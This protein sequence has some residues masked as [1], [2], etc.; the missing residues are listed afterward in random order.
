[1]LHKSRLQFLRFLVGAAL[2]VVAG[3]LAWI[4]VVKADEIAVKADEQRLVKQDLTPV[5]GA[6]LDR[7]LMHMAVSVPTYTLVASPADMKPTEQQ[8]AALQLGELLGLDPAELLKQFKENDTSKYLPLKDKLNLEQKN[9]IEA[10]KLPQMYL[11]QDAQRTYPNKSVA[12]KII[13]YLA[14]GKGAAGLEAQ[15][16][17]QLTGQKGY[18]L[19]EWTYGNTPIESTI[20]EKKE[21][22]PGR[23]LVLSIDLSLQR[24]A[25]AKLDEV[26]KKTDAKRAAIL[27]MDIHTGEILIMA[28]R[29]GADPGDRTTWG[30]PID[31][32]RIQ[33]W[34]VTA[35]PPGSIFKAITS[36]AALEERAITL[37]TPFIDTG[38][39]RLNGCTIRNWDGYVTP[40][41]EPM[42]LARLMQRSSNV[43]LIQVG[44]AVGR[45]SFVKYLQGFGFFEKTGIDLPYE[46]AANTGDKF[47]DKRD[48]DWAGMYIGQHLE[49][50]PLQ[51]VQAVSAIANG[52]KLVQPHLVREIREDGKVIWAAETK[53][54]RQVIS[55]A[56]AK[57]VRE[58]M[59]SVVEKGY[60]TA[61]PAGYTAGGKTGTAQKYENGREKERKIADFIGFAPAGNPQVVM[62]VVIDEPEGQGFGGVLAAPVFGEFMPQVL[63]AIGIAPDRTDNPGAQQAP[64]VAVQGIV[65]DVQWLPTAWA[66]ARLAEAGFTPRLKGSGTKVAA[67]SLQPGSGAKAG[68]V[69]ELTQVQGNPADEIVQVPDFTGLSLAEAN[70]LATELGLTLKTGGSGFVADQEPKKGAVVPARATLTV[71]LAPRP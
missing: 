15:Y 49:V 34:T 55:E 27:V 11:M 59:V 17:E 20:K 63:R 44:Q 41:P 10:A 46:Q 2:V 40:D 58:V 12:N 65:P 4:Q 30:D 23:D 25:E 62:M 3:R 69:V 66:E 16:E 19:A 21:S 47:E 56:T 36:S 42:P 29:P 70:R 61:L 67:Q 8:Q 32:G 18:V 31:Y 37:E 43:G 13:G 71:R 24:A 57:E 35:M 68:T 28:E 6:I 38:E 33:P 1:M 14:D 60:R 22:I 7:N 48:C 52:G 39:L 64:P 54:K 5:R 9:K 51:M 26:M 53:A 50:T 45:D